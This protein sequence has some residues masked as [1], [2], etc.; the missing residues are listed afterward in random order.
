MCC[1]RRRPNTSPSGWDG[2]SKRPTTGAHCTGSLM[3]TSSRTS[4]GIGTRDWWCASPT[5]VSPE[6]GGDERAGPIRREGNERAEG[7]RLEACPPPPLPGQRGTGGADQEQR[8]QRQRRGPERTGAER[9]WEQERHQRDG[10]GGHERQ[11]RRR[12]VLPRV[13]LF[14]GKVLSGAHPFV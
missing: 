11:E 4:G 2:R 5:D 6:G 12:T 14:F 7:Q 8:R 10:A 1:S 9:T 3:R 13:G